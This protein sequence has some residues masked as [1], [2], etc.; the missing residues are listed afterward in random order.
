MMWVSGLL[1]YHGIFSY[2]IDSIA[3]NGESNNA[4]SSEAYQ[5]FHSNKVRHSWELGYN[6]FNLKAGMEQRQFYLMGD[7]NCFIA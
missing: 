5:Y 4:K 1:L 7:G 3:T 2:F 6:C